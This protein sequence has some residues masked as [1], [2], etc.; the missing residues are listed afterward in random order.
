M[1]R[2]ETIGFIGLGSMGSAMA[3][4]LSAAG[5]RVLGFDRAD[6]AGAS[7]IE[8]GGR[9]A[10]SVEE[11]GRECGIVFLSL[12]TPQIMRE[13]VLGAAGLVHGGPRMI[14]DLSTSG[15]RASA[16]V[17]E[18]LERAGIAFVDAPVS[19]GR[20]GALA[21]RLSL[22]AACKEI[23]WREVE[24][25]LLTFGRVFHVGEAAGQGQMMK[26]V[27]NMLSAAALVVTSEG[28]ALG[29]KAGLDPKAMIEVLNASSGANSATADKFPRAVLPRTFD[30]GF[31]TGLAL[32]DVRMCLEE[33][34]ANDVPMLVGGV[35][36][37]MLTI[38]QSRHGPQS[39]FTRLAQ[40]VEQWAGTEIA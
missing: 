6:G 34:Q 31:A 8:A 27:N 17:A 21:G 16:E 22:M 37:D 12:P 7:L 15:P 11:I 25:L 9:M 2:R 40:I 29:V 3:P 18:Q 33:A 19:G 26:L 13:V 32:K 35:V 38:T 20:A 36:R 39:D 30:F 1:S 5:H 10:G 4:R 14:V 28:V 23:D 24:P